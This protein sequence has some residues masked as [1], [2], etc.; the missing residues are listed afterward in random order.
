VS[1][2]GA[3]FFE[4][5]S[6]GVNCT[7]KICGGPVGKVLFGKELPYSPRQTE[8]DVNEGKRAH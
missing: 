1:S 3:E 8:E 2:G 4:M 7:R 5:D 6:M